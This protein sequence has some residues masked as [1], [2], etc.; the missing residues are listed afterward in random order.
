MGKQ[1]WRKEAVPRKQVVPS[2][3]GGAPP[4]EAK[5]R[6]QVEVLTRGSTFVMSVV[7]FYGEF[8]TGELGS[9][10]GCREASTHANIL[11]EDLRSF[12]GDV[13]RTTRVCTN[14]EDN[15]RTVFPVCVHWYAF[16][17]GG[18]DGDGAPEDVRLEKPSHVEVDKHDQLRVA[19][20]VDTKSWNSVEGS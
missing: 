11:V 2:C 15:R 19:K 5:A 10:I 1:T 9:G 18:V 3:V 17:V 8:Q 4:G 20:R 7:E 12:I 13:S 6:K 16:L 14:R